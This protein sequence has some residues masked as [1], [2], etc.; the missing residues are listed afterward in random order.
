MESEKLRKVVLVF[1]MD[2]VVMLSLHS[3]VLFCCIPRVIRFD[4]FTV[5]DFVL[6][7]NRKLFQWF[8]L[9]CDDAYRNTT[10]VASRVVNIAVLVLLPIV[11]AILFEYDASIGDTFCMQYRHGYWR[12]FF[13]YFLAIFDTSTSVIR[14]TSY[15]IFPQST[16]K[17]ICMW[18]DPVTLRLKNN[19][20]NSTPAY[21][22]M[23]HSIAWLTCHQHAICSAAV[24]TASDTT[25]NSLQETT[26]IVH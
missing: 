21:K 18:V 3:F 5:P 26:W 1:F 16:Y 20:Q 7:C 15:R 4:V 24:L 17:A 11:S 23:P 6:I 19:V 22:A 13:F 10:T 12:Y 25:C 8:S 2:Y 14:C 9:L